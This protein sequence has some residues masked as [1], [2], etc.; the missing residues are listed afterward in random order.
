MNFNPT[1]N[2]ILLGVFGSRG[3][4]MHTPTSDT[5]VVGITIP[6]KEYW[7]GFAHTFE[8]AKNADITS[9]LN[10]DDMNPEKEVE[11]TIFGISKFFHL[12][13][14]CNPNILEIAWMPDENVRFE[15]SW[16]A[17]V[18]HHRELFLSTKVRFT[19]CGYAYSQ[20]KRI[21]THRRWLLDPKTTKP[22]RSDF[23]LPEIINPK[24]KEAEAMIRA[25]I[26]RWQMHDLQLEKAQ[27]MELEDK[28]ADY[29]AQDFQTVLAEEGDDK[30]RTLA[31]T[32]IGFD[33]NLMEL[34]QKE[35]EYHKALQDWK[36]YQT[37]QRQRNPARAELEA[38]SGYDTKHAAHLVRLMRMAEEILLGKGVIVKRPDADELLAIRDGIWSYDELMQYVQTQEDKVEKLYENNQNIPKKVNVNRL[39]DICMS[40][41]ESF[42][43]RAKD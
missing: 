37:W 32:K 41:A 19:F 36:N 30:A 17:T 4:G 2:M 29:L 27:R 31:M 14:Q 16:G 12:C 15:N 9:F 33:D 13:S 42:L 22:E 3:Y 28:L 26:S 23:G 35:N 10:T 20:L 24:V 38:K 8:Q 34:I 5:D 1:D 11:S 40:V 43:A 6:P 25:Q 18:R 21:N 39:N 7:L